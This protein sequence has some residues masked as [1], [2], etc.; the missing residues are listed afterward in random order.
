[1]GGV[2]ERKKKLRK[3]KLTETLN[4]H[5]AVIV[6]GDHNPKGYF[7]IAGASFP[8]I[9]ISIAVPEKLQSNP[10]LINELSDEAISCIFKAMKI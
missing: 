6:H 7:E 1:M 9:E 2:Y 8:N 3:V 10:S 4:K 5:K